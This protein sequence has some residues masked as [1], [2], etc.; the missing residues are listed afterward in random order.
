[1]TDSTLEEEIRAALRHRADRAPRSARDP[2]DARLG[3]RRSITRLVAAGAAASVVAAIALG[4]AYRPD[5]SQVVTS[6]GDRGGTPVAPGNT[7]ERQ[8]P[9]SG[10]VPRLGFDPPGFRFERVQE[11]DRSAAAPTSTVRVAPGGQPVPAV[12]SFGRSR[13][14]SPMLFVRT[15]EQGD[16]ET[17]GL[18]RSEF[19]DPFPVRGVTGYASRERAMDRG[20]N[21]SVE[22]PDGRALYAIVIGFG[23]DDVTRIFDG[24]APRPDGSWEATV[25]PRGITELEPSQVWG[26]CS[27]SAVGDLAGDEVG[28]FEVNLYGDA[29]DWRLADRAASTV[30]AIAAV[31]IDGVPAAIGSYRHDDHWVMFE[32]QPGRTMEIRAS[33]MSREDVMAIIARARFVDEATWQTMQP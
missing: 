7:P 30:G 22:L 15:I 20:W 21:L 17:F 13:Y 19:G 26:G 6:S 9:P 4:T 18:V 33:S 1:M 31:T 25:L 10:S 29:F 23:L 5:R 11:C 32:P 14:E 3:A 2:L 16:R 12:Q 27:Y 28:A 24:L 8:Q